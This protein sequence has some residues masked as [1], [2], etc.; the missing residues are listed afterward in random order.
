MVACGFFLIVLL[1][2]L[3]I[4]GLLIGVINF[5]V[6]KKEAY[7]EETFTVSTSVVVVVVVGAV[8]DS[9]LLTTGCGWGCT[10]SG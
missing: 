5:S 10:G 7:A 1:V 2:L 6:R 4:L 8:Y 3:I 9:V